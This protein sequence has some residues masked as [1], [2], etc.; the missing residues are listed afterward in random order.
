MSHN[1]QHKL[2]H[3]P[4]CSHFDFDEDPLDWEKDQSIPYLAHCLAGSVAGITEHVTMLPVDTIKTHMQVNEG[5][6]SAYQTAR[7]L[8]NTEGLSKFWRGASVLASGCVPAHAAYF[9]VYELAK[10]NLLPKFHDKNDQIHPHAYALVGAL[11]TSVHDLILTPFDMLKQR[12]QLAPKGLTGVGSLLGYIL[13]KEGVLSLYRGYPITLMMNV[14]QAAAIV[15][16]NESLKILYKP[17]DGHNIFSYFMCAGIAGSVAAMLTIP[18]DNIKTRLQTQNFFTESRRELEKNPRAAGQVNLSR[19]QKSFFATVKESSCCSKIDNI[20][21][22][23]ILDTTKA[24]FREEGMR[25][26]YKGM[27]PR[28]ITLAPASAI[29]WTAYETLKKLFIN[30]KSH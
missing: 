29:S 12:S 23:N 5:R 30:K 14:P 10:L 18:M 27:W 13:K 6:F 8:Y 24:I 9:T 26:F 2:H 28:M 22:H 17:K 11:A 7:M 25:G 1:D 15:S 4:T 19:A 21:Y 20:K 16:V 3:C